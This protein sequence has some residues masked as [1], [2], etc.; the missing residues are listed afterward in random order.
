MHIPLGLK[1]CDFLT[2]STDPFLAVKTCTDE[3]DEAGFIKLSKR[4]PFV[5]I[6]KPGGSYYYTI[7]RSTLVA[8]S[9]GA[10]FKGGNG[11]KIVGGHTG[12]LNYCALIVE[13]A[14]TT[15]SYIPIISHSLMNN[16]YVTYIILDSPYLKVK[17][18]SKRSGSGCVQLGVECYGGGLWHTWFDR[19]CLF[20]Q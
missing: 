6:L 15:T 14:A 20:H 18:I 19:E 5:G 8:F 17:P 7:N 13:A 10:K 9:V 4:E 16:Y 11:F 3:L 2:K 12:E 1:A